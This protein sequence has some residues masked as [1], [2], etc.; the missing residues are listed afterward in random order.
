MLF[1]GAVSAG[2]EA[3]ITV[4]VNVTENGQSLA[5]LSRT[6][7]PGEPI[8]VCVGSPVT[9]PEDI[10]ISNP[11][12]CEGVSVNIA[13]MSPKQ[14]S[15]KIDYNVEYYKKSSRISTVDARLPMFEG[16]AIKGTSTV[17]RGSI[18]E[19]KSGTLQMSLSTD[20]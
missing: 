11:R 4:H 1:A 18:I 20:F 7:K 17:S 16:A 19:G 13:P 5:T 9:Y 12:D 8:K 2:S 6:V 14:E 15:L 10:R 3:P